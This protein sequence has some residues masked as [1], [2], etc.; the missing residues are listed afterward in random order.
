MR[1]TVLTPRQHI[2]DEFVRKRQAVSG[3]EAQAKAGLTSD[4]LIR[5]M[6]V[7]RLL[8]MFHHNTELTKEVW[9]EACELDERRRGRKV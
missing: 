2:E 5:Q 7:A 6:T 9:N 3:G 1:F 4:D 8:T